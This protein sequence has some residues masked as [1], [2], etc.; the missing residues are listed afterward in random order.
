MAGGGE[1]C[2]QGGCCL[3]CHLKHFNEVGIG[4][5]SVPPLLRSCFDA[6]AVVLHK[7]QQIPAKAE[8]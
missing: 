2:V 4:F 6:L 7:I 1:G 5:G 8:V 3:G